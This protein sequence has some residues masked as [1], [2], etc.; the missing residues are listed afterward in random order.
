MTSAD[1]GR[2]SDFEHGI[3][4]LELFNNQDQEITANDASAGVTNIHARSAVDLQI[5]THAVV[6][7]SDAS[8]N[9]TWYLDKL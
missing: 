1:S 2:F 5:G 4:F 6:C 8:N 7:W 3:Y 9:L